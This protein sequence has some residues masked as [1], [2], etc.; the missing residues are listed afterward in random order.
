M[1]STPPKSASLTPADLFLAVLVVSVWGGNFIAA[2]EALHHFPPYYVTAL[3][4]CFVSLLLVPFVK[5]PPWREMKKIIMVSTTLG[6]G[7]LSMLFAAMSQGLDIAS[8]ALMAQLGV[9]IA[10][11]LGAI[12]LN[13]KMGVWRMSGMAISFLGVVFLM[14]SP[15]VLNHLPAFFIALFAATAW[16]VAN[17][18]IKR[19][20]GIT[21]FAQLGWMAF[22]A[23]P[24]LLV[25][26]Y[27]LEQNQIELTRSATIAVWSALS[28]TV[29]GS[30]LLAYGLWYY[31]L[32]KYDISQIAPITLLGPFVSIAI[33][34][35][36]YGDPLTM[37]VI[38]GS[39]LTILGVGIIVVRRPKFTN[40]GKSAD[41]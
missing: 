22:F 9:P 20:H 39:A 40:I 26:S 4:F 34:H 2:K 28:Y 35:L 11:A 3:R 24:Q 8:T 16:A 27:F 6:V 10:C 41:S 31:L 29:L 32:K 7:H 38:L 21:I 37:P 12:F 18:I 14:G 13:D 25:I 30:T 23:V 19:I 33:G 1:S 15:N 5:M 36:V 17:I